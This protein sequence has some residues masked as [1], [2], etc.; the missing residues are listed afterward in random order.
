M[1]IGFLRWPTSVTAQ[2]TLPRHNL[3]SHGTT[4]FLMALNLLSSRHNLLSH[5]TTYFL[6]CTIYFLTAQPTFFTPQFTFS[7]H[8]LLFS[9]HNSLSHGKNYFFILT[10]TFLLVTAQLT[11]SRR[12]SIESQ[13]NVFVQCR[14]W[15]KF[16]GGAQLG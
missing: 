6:H 9:R 7:R 13:R 5:G 14:S 16:F 12:K 15:A 11:F 4:Y 10:I 1:D 3:L 2:P 8:N